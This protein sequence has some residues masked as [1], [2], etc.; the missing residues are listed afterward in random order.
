MSAH[1]PSESQKKL[2]GVGNVALL[3]NEHITYD[4]QRHPYEYIKTYYISSQ[5]AYTFRT[6]F[7]AER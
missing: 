1:L 3:L 6:G 4:E 7:L 2:L 5:Y